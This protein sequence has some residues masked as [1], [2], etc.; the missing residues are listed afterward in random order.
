MCDKLYKILLKLKHSD[1]GAALLYFALIMPVFVG[2]AGLGFDATLWFMEKRQL[3]SVADSSAITAA[4]ALSKDQTEQEILIAATADAGQNNFHTGGYNTI[5][6]SS[7]PTTGAYAGLAN[8]V[9]VTVSR[10]GD[11]MFTAML[12][13]GRTIIETSATAAILT[14]GEHCILAL[15]DT[16]DRALEFSGTSDV[17]INCG[18]ASNSNSSESIYLN[19]TASLSADP[20]A[21]SYGDIFEGSNATL[22]TPNPIQPFSQRST[23]PYGPDGRDLQVPA[24][25]STCAE[26]RLRVN[27]GT[28]ILTPGRYCDGMIFGA[29]AD[30]T[31][32]PGVYIIDGGEFNVGS[33]TTVTGTDVT[34]VLTGPTIAEIATIKIRAGADL[35]L[36]APSTGYWSGIVFF[37][38][39]NAVY[40]DGSNTFLGGADMNLKGAVYF[41]SQELVFSGGTAGVSGCLLLI[42]NKVTFSGNSALVNDQ[43][44]CA[45]V[46]IDEGTIARTIVTLEE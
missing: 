31:F 22:D 45:A 5:V 20:S 16:R 24:S 21:Q 43:S 13:L 19:G 10:P 25:P 3:Q 39:P 8:Y 40:A 15:D 41:P 12:G 6:V 26:T 42:G 36:A 27:G 23:D 30:V 38:D 17:D 35:N 1:S 32:E 29:G 37:Q 7:P 2:F 34:I 9:M 4:Y 18:V 33:G 14:S 11:R 46:G 28:H 44:D